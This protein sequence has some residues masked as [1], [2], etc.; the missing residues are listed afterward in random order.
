MFK[1]ILCCVALVAIPLAALWGL[2]GLA[3]PWYRADEMYSAEDATAAERLEFRV[4]QELHRIRKDE[5]AWTIRL[6]DK[7]TNAWLATRLQAWLRGQDIKWPAGVNAP[8]IRSENGWMELAATVADL[9]GRVCRLR[10]DPR[11]EDDQLGLELGA[12]SVG[13]LP[14]MLPADVIV[15]AAILDALRHELPGAVLDLVDGRAV[16]ITAL[17]PLPGVLEVDLR[18]SDVPLN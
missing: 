18:T 9:D 16:H 1:R 7:V 5:P 8:R 15:P 13:R 3:P 14:R 12:V 17:R 11:V 10:L 4:Q 2:A 6:P